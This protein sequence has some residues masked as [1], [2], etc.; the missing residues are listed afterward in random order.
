MSGTILD[1]GNIAMNPPPQ[2]LHLQK[3]YSKDRQDKSE[4]I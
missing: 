1:A 4:N 3:F 2:F